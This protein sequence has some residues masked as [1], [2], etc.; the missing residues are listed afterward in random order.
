MGEEDDQTSR[1][2]QSQPGQ[3]QPGAWVMKQSTYLSNPLNELWSRAAVNL[4]HYLLKPQRVRRII[5][6]Y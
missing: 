1:P 5:D 6:I 2:G 3:S 4:W